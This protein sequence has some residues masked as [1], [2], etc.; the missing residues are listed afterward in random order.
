MTV[1]IEWREEEAHCWHCGGQGCKQCGMVCYAEWKCYVCKAT[2]EGDLEGQSACPECGE[3]PIVVEPRP[4]N[5]PDY[6]D[7]GEQL[8]ELT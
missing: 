4:T 8:E 6:E 7:W 1:Y 5:E 3:G 2:G